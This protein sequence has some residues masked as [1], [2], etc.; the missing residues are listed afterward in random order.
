MENEKFGIDALEKV[1]V[2]SVDVFEV[3]KDKLSDGFQWMDVIPIA[4]EAKDLNFLITEWTKLGQQFNDIDPEEF[5]QLVGKLVD[6]L[7]FVKE[8][9]KVFIMKLAA[10]AVAG[11]DVYEAFN[12]LKKDD[13]DE[14]DTLAPLTDTEV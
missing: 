5:E 4:A 14:V 2:E 9:V 6:E 7:G 10:F 12:D 1:I 11:Y 13:G 8:K 3:A